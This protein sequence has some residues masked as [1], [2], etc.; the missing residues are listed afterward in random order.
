MTSSEEEAEKKK[1]QVE[2][3]AQTNS[4]KQEGQPDQAKVE[5]SEI[6][7]KGDRGQKGVQTKGWDQ[8]KLARRKGAKR[9]KCQGARVPR[10]DAVNGRGSQASFL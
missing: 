9:K 6:Q 7:G 8:N 4:R 2:K 1:C 5:T 10:D 3:D